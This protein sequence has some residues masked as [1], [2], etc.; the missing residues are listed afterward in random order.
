MIQKYKTFEALLLPAHEPENSDNRKTITSLQS[1]YKLTN[2]QIKEVG[3]K[4]NSLL[5][6]GTYITVK[7]VN[8]DFMLISNN[9]PSTIF[10]MT[11]G[12]L[13][14]I[15]PYKNIKVDDDSL[16]I[17]VRVDECL[18]ILSVKDDYEITFIRPKIVV[19]EHDPFGEEDWG[20][21]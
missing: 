8:L 9:E 7:D 12:V 16:I 17:Y 4:I 18:F 5:T 1:L 15:G 13:S 20:E 21:D 2:N 14:S 6:D 19:S 3:N 11:P 10:G